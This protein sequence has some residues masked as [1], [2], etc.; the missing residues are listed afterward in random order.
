MCWT[1][2]DNRQNYAEHTKIKHKEFLICALYKNYVII[3]RASMHIYCKSLYRL[4]IAKFVCIYRML[5]VL[6]DFLGLRT[7]SMTAKSLEN[8]KFQIVSKCG[9]AL[10][11]ARI[12]GFWGW[13]V[14]YHY[15]LKSFLLKV[16]YRQNKELFVHRKQNF[17]IK[18]IRI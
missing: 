14:L 18:S 7:L 17:F 6:T 13:F 16:M 12:I 1:G 4:C 5:I 9:I 15:S 11:S 3:L 2:I 8:W 10:S